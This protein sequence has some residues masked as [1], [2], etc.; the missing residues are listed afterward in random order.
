[1]TVVS[2]WPT[3]WQ[4]GILLALGNFPYNLIPLSPPLGAKILIGPVSHIQYSY[5]K[6]FMSTV[7]QSKWMNYFGVEGLGGKV[8]LTLGSFMGSYKVLLTAGRGGLNSSEW[9]ALKKH[10]PQAIGSRDHGSVSHSQMVLRIDR[11]LAHV[12]LLSHL[13]SPVAANTH[14]FPACCTPAQCRLQKSQRCLRTWA[15]PSQQPSYNRKALT[16]I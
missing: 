4:A 12:G 3:A 13:P 10:K 2:S 16:K 5:I 1:M 14:Y 9:A 8:V 6:Q 15:L 11:L 7:C